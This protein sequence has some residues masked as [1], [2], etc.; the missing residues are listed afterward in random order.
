MTTDDNLIFYTHPMSRGRTV[1]WM[2]EEIGMPYETVYLDFGTAMK[3][4][5]YRAINPMGKV[6]TLRHGHTVIT[7]AAA[8]CA[9]LADAFPQTG[10]APA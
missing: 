3:A 5:E 10:L 8:I 1:R 4:A 7:E 2:L 9:Y 6:P